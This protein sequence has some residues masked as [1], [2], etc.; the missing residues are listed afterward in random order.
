MAYYDSLTPYIST[1]NPDTVNDATNYAP[2]ALGAIYPYQDRTY[3]VVQ[4]DPDADASSPIGEVEEGQL[5][6]WRN[7][8][9]FIVTNDRRL[10]MELGVEPEPEEEEEDDEKDNGKDKD[11]D[12]D[13]DAPPKPPSAPAG[14]A[15]LPAPAPVATKTRGTQDPTKS[16]TKKPVSKR[17]DGKTIKDTVPDAYRNLVAGIFRTAVKPGN[18]CHILK[19]GYDIPL[20]DGGLTFAAG[21]VLIAGSNATAGIDKVAPGT[22]PGFRTLGMARGPAE[23]GI[24]RA[25][26]HID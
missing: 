6:Y 8:K 11:K 15:S 25:D 23:D 19:S 10:A 17:K 9:L 22:A 5:A 12:K 4:L 21:D 26:I 1:G 20:P 13:K 7:R 18:I 2:G 3:Q 14:R 16:K 24:V